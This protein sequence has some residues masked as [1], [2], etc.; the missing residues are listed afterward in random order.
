MNDT[1]LELMSGALALEHLNLSPATTLDEVEAELRRYAEED[2][3]RSWLIGRNGDSELFATANVAAR[4]MLDEVVDDRPV[5]VV[6]EDETVGWANSKAL[7]M[8]AINRRTRSQQ[9]GTI[10]KDRRTGEPTGVLR[11]SAVDLVIRVLPK[12]TQ[13]EKIA[14]LRVAIAEAHKVGITSVQTVHTSDEELRLLDEIRQ[15]GD[16]TLRV[17][18]S[19]AVGPNVTEAQVLE[20]NKLREAYP[21]DPTLKFGGIEIVCPCDPAQIGRAVACSTST[22]GTVMVR[23][24]SGADVRAAVEAFDHAVAGNPSRSRERRYRVDDTL[25]TEAGARILFGSDWPAAALDPHEAIEEGVA[26]PGELRNAID[27]Y[28]SHAAYASYDEHRKG[29]LAP[30]MLADI[31]ILSN[32]IFENRPDAVKESAVTVTIFDGKVVYQRPAATS[33]D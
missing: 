23:T 1:R 9:P 28:T 21:D 6:S 2:L 29:T 24:A 3:S 30:G 13:A 27:A 10:V 16:L 33:N 14:A 5:F 4:A 12:P 17:Y 18:G 19:I 11:G 22:T 8:A 20:F 15:Q 32:D 26:A 31:V 7:E 25:L